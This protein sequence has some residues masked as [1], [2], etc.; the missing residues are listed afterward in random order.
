MERKIPYSAIQ[1]SL[2]VRLESKEDLA[3]AYT[4]GVA[5]LCRQIAA[6]KD[7]AYSLTLKKNAV[8]VLS[9]GSRV[10]GLG[11]IGPLAGLPVM[12]GKAA[13]F[14]RFAG[15]DAFPLSVDAKSADELVALAKA[16]AP[17]F[18]G[19]NLEDISAPKC[20]EVERRLIEELDIPVMH[21]DQHGT[22][23]VALAGAL[24]ALPL[25]GKKLSGAKV[26]V[27]GAG[28]AGSAIA[29][30]V[31]AAG[32]KDVIS[33]DRQGALHSG[34][35]GLDRHK[36]ELAEITNKAK[37][38]G[39]LQ[40]CCEGADLLIGASSPGAFARAHIS[41]MASKPI[42]FAL[43]NPDPEISAQEAALAGAFIYASARS[44]F[45]N[46]INNAVAF[47]GIFRGALDVRASRITEG[48]KM[49]AAQALAARVS[50]VGATPGYIIP[51]PFDP[52]AH[53]KVAF[54]VA[55]QAMREG[56]ARVKLSEA[57]LASAIRSRIPKAES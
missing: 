30:L 20:F 32:A 18:G 21:D 22:A 19:I 57:E 51:S 29:K 44:D 33:F 24:S 50:E 17:T 38:T 15:V 12:E 11:N 47:P 9:D 6:D 36:L 52:E 43:S 45:P 10:L 25:A 7:K 14:K 34:R 46:Q 2:A 23:V 53:F 13:L 56:V 40:E 41:A 26:I 42:V 3:E 48:M 5:G 8:A 35:E 54:A 4:P 49:A 16:I 27:N 31:A 55:S 37:F 28:A 39:S 1:T